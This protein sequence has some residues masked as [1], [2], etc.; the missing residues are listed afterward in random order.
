MTFL[1]QIQHLFERTYTPTGVNLEDCLIGKDRCLELSNL[2]GPMAHELSMEG[3]TFFRIVDGK[4]YLAIYYSPKVI[5]ALEEH[6]PFHEL[7]HHNIRPL[8]TFIEELNHAVHASLLFME[9]R[10]EVD[11]ED[12]LC[13]LELQAKIDTYLTLKL[14]ITIL[15]ERR[16]VLVKQERW[17]QQCL[18]KQESFSY[19]QEQ[20]QRR[21]RETNRLGL[22]LVRF[23]DQMDASKRIEL[24]REL[25]P[26]SFTAK[27]DYILSLS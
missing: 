5:E 16:H 4:L 6:H 27:K 22:K 23:L 13:N 9:N 2:A 26:L 7:S 3:R 8:I 11:R 25:R 21:Y 17:L 1:R 24:I 12:V 20:L 18:F 14:I 15:R 10:L 19:R